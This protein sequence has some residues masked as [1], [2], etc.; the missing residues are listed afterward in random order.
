ML[1][2]IGVV[3][4]AGCGGGD[5]GARPDVERVARELERAWPSVIVLVSDDGEE[6]AATAGAQRPAEDQRFRIGS[7]TKTFTAAIVLQL[8]D[9]G[10]VRLA[11]TLDDYLPGVVPRGDRITIRQLLAHRSGLP[12]YSD[13][14]TWFEPAR[15]SPTIRPIDI[16]RFAASQRPSF[17]PG[18]QWRYSN[19]NYVALG[20]V[21]EKVTGHSY[22]QEL[23]QRIFEPLG[24][25]QTELPEA[26]V[27]PDLED[28]GENPNVS[29]AAGAI[30]SD[31]HDLARFYSALLSGRL[32]S[33][34][35]L[36][37]MEQRTI[38]VGGGTVTA[39]G[40]G[41]WSIDLSCG[42]FWGHEGG[43]L[44]YGTLVEASEDGKR[45]AVVSVHGGEGGDQPPDL[46][47]LLCPEQERASG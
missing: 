2:V 13:F 19:T 17:A 46:E 5:S 1:V 18:S 4:L 45:V 41:L 35:S 36:A 37:E 12:N 21:I 38:V 47:A 24:L 7:V 3:L 16:L 31:A 14:T 40:R 27:V 23:E 10:K 22:G 20:L 29:W 32:V 6:Y 26:D 43:I 15:R 33:D 25:E 11:G 28:E 44:G 9:E 42:R 34:E 39:V 8:V 30:V